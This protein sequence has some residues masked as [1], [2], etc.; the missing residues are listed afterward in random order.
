[1]KRGEHH[2]AWA[3]DR[4]LTLTVVPRNAAKPV[5]PGWQP[6]E[7]RSYHWKICMPIHT[8]AGWEDEKGHIF[9]ESSRVH[10][11]AFPFFPPDREEDW[12]P[13]V[14]TKADFVRWSIDPSQP[15]GSQLPDPLVVLDCPSEFPRIDERF[16]SHQYD[17]SWLNVFIPD[18]SDVS[19]NIFQGLNGLAMHSNKT[20][21]TKWFRAGHDSLIQEPIFIPRTDDSP[22][23]DGWVIALIERLGKES[24]CDLVVIDTK[25]FE[26]PVAFV[27]LPFH[28]KA[29]IH[30]NWVNAKALGGYKSIVRQ[31]PELKVSGKGALE[32]L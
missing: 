4:N 25:E 8:A 14:E 9:I 11:N 12:K 28:V 5:A 22:E 15:D 20:G 13:D 29:Q 19:K 31:L 2:W 1:M 18:R 16:M 24:R 27:Q 3:P 23:G 26:T 17:I 7:I 6:N 30:G 32:P 10:G 21:E